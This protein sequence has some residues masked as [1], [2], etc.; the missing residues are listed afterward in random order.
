MCMPVCVYL[1]GANVYTEAHA[2]VCVYVWGA[3]MYTGSRAPVYVYVWGA[4]VKDRVHVHMWKTKDSPKYHSSGPTHHFVFETEFLT[5]VLGI[6]LRS[7]CSHSE[8]FISCN[9]SPA[10]SELLHLCFPREF[11]KFVFIVVI[12]EAE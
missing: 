6:E 3:H 11:Y 9:I 10:H 5:W 7:S 1:W 2:P 8:Q 4:H 12:L